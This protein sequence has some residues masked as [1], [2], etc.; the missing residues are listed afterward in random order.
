MPIALQVAADGAL[1]DPVLLLIA[2]LLGA[3]VGLREQRIEQQLDQ[4]EALAERLHDRLR[5]LLPVE[6]AAAHSRSSCSPTTARCRR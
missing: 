6:I 1:P 3:F 5:K 4:V 2:A